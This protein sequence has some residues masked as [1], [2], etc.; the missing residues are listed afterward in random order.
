[1]DD[2]SLPYEIVIKG[3]VKTVERG[4]QGLGERPQLFLGRH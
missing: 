3:T 1:M 4:L 2:E